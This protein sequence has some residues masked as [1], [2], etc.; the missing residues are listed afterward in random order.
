MK[1]TRE[2]N[3]E[4]LRRFAHLD[5]AGWRETRCDRRLPGSDRACTRAKGHRGPHAS[6]GLFSRLH[7]VWGRGSG[8]AGSP[9][10]IRGRARSGGGGAG[11]RRPVGLRSRD[12]GGALD[13]LKA[14][15]GWIGDH[16]EEILLLA[17]FAAFVWFALDWLMIIFR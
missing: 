17:F 13:R 6:H 11:H 3:R 12:P 2:K 5:R 4:A 10:E 7:A 9:A 16:A 1:L 8:D 14:G 15:L